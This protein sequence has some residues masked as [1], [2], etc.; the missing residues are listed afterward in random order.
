MRI[1]HIAM[2]TKDI[3]KMRIFYEFFFKAH[4]SEKY[5]N[6]AKEFSSYFMTFESGARLE[7]MYSPHVLSSDEPTERLGYAHI[8]MSLGSRHAVNKVTETLR[9]SG[10]GVIGEPRVT[11]D[12]YYESVVLDPE[13]NSIELVE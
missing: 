9:Q 5:E 10:Y 13:G 7:L 11:G 4:A 6:P 3:E 12:G 2:W 1:S 8:A